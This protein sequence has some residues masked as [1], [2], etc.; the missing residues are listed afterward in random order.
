[1]THS[2][3]N[4]K[5]PCNRS[6]KVLWIFF[7]VNVFEQHANWLS[8]DLPSFNE[9]RRRFKAINATL[10]LRLNRHARH[11]ISRKQ[12]YGGTGDPLHDWQYLSQLGEQR[13]ALRRIAQPVLYSGSTV[14]GDPQLF[15]FGIGALKLFIRPL[16]VLA[17][18][19][20]IRISSRC[21]FLQTF[22]K[23]HVS[24]HS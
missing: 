2:F 11:Y 6:K 15:S 1:M 10:M 21:H 8:I 4:F 22:L 16:L 14:E 5:S 19:F 9:R 18:Q 17:D 13:I 23:W 7:G 20:Y 24:K 3:H 12:D